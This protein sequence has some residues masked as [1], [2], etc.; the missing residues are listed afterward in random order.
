MTATPEK[1]VQG[2]DLAD[3]AIKANPYPNYRWLRDNAPAYR[4]PGTPMWV[5]SR[6]QDIDR[7]LYGDR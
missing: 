5:I 4:L 2:F 6:H 1:P 3:P 7:I